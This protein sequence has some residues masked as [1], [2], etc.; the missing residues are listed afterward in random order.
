M[1]RLL[2]TAF[3][4]VCLFYVFQAIPMPDDPQAAPT[5]PNSL[6]NIADQV[7]K[8]WNSASDTLNQKMGEWMNES[9]FND[10]IDKAKTLLNQAGDHIRK[11]AEKIGEKLHD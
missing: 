6:D 9:N 4:M 2:F 10:A 1:A 3:L 7:K 5:T 8:A 11:E